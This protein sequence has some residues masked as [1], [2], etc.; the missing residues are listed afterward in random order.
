MG[1][2]PSRD[3]GLPVKLR[4]YERHRRRESGVRGKPV[5]HEGDNPELG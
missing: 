2:P 4:T 3:V 5:H 1:D